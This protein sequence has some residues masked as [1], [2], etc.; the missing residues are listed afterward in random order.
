MNLNILALADGL[1]I[2]LNP[3][4][5]EFYLRRNAQKIWSVYLNSEKKIFDDY[6]DSEIADQ[7]NGSLATLINEYTEKKQPEYIIGAK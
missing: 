4:G 2:I 5:Y 3:H 7:L 1:I 6:L